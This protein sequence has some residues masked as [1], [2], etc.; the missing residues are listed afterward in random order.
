MA[1]KTHLTTQEIADLLM[2][3]PIVVFDWVQQGRLHVQLRADDEHRFDLESMQ[4]FARHY[5]LTLN[6]P[7]CERLR[8]LIVDSDVRAAQTLIELFETLSETTEAIAV[9]NVFDV[10]R[11]LSV[12]Q[13]HVVLLDLQILQAVEICRRI[14]N[15]HG[16]RHIRVVAMAGPAAAMHRQRILL[17]GAETCLDKPLDHQT[18]FDVVGLCSDTAPIDYDLAQDN[19]Q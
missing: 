8:M 3:S 7:G 10:G 17:A 15:G 16:T 2:I 18:L 11:Q 5:G 13:P 6:R 19:C 12:F 14:R 4:Q 1:Q 9:H